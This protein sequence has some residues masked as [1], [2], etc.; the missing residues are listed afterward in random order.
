M[1][2]CT[3]KQHYYKRQSTLIPGFN[4]L[5]SNLKGQRS[6]NLVL[7]NLS[8]LNQ[9]IVDNVILVAAKYCKLSSNK[10]Y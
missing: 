4:N 10:F 9:L 3:N 2:S 7:P 5:I 6:N 1:K 8:A